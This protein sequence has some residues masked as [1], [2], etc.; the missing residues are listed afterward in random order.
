MSEKVSKPKAIKGLSVNYNG[1][2]YKNITSISRGYD[3]NSFHY[4]DESG[5]EFS[6][7]PPPGTSFDLVQE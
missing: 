3:Y 4:I 2:T 1:S 5:T 7:Y 6:V